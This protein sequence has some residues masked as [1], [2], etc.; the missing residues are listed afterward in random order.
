MLCYC[1]CSIFF[2]FKQKTAY[3]M[4]ISD[5]SSDVCSSDL[6][7]LVLAARIAPRLGALIVGMNLNG[8]IFAGEQIFDEQFRLASVGHLKPDFPNRL[9]AVHPV[10]ESGPKGPAAPGFSTLLEMSFTTPVS[11]L[12]PSHRHNDRSAGGIPPRQ[13]R[14]TA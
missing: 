10:I 6:P 1:V 5:W 12:L 14:T 9:A 2:F 13:G 11:T 8:Q 7:C 4:R 3:E